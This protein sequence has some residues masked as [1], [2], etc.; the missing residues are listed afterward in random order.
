MNVVVRQSHS[1]RGGFRGQSCVRRELAQRSCWDGRRGE[2]ENT[3]LVRVSGY[4]SAK[5]NRLLAQQLFAPSLGRPFSP[6]PPL[7]SPA[8][9]LGG[10]LSGFL[11]CFFISRWTSS[12]GFSAS[13]GGFLD[14]SSGST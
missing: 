12:R 11:S 3:V 9:Q 7:L 10:G 5:G 13:C 2:R 8:A 6:S 14:L 1:K 4:D